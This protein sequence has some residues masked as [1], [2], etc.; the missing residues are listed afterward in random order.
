MFTSRAE[1]RLLLREDN[2]DQ[3]LSTLGY[4][5]GLLHDQEYG[6]FVSKQESV[7]QERS[8]LASTRLSLNSSELEWMEHKGLTE[9]QKGTSLEHLLRRPE[10]TYDDL[11]EFDDVSRETSAVIRE[12]VEIQI[13]YQGYIE[14]QLEQIERSGKLENT[15]IPVEI[16]F[17]AIN[18]LTTEVREKLDKIR[19]GTLGQ[20]S[21]IPGVTPAAISVLSIAIKAHVGMKNKAIQ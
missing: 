7:V 6:L 2:A 21:R 18:G 8:R 19:P 5:I 9:L 14:R 16:D 13:K 20:A 4:S 3:R 1:Y 12:Q 11:L 10:I 15:R 17:S